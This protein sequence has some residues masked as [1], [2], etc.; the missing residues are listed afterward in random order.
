ML[1][2]EDGQ[3]SQNETDVSHVKSADH[4]ASAAAGFCRWERRQPMRDKDVD[5]G[6]DTVDALLS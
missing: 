3:G 4:W 6:A 5:L 1:A 2:V